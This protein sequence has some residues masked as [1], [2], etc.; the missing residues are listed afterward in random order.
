KKKE[1]SLDYNN[2]FLGE[3]EC[4]SL[5]LDKE[6]WRDE[7]KR[8]DHLKQDQTMLVIKRF[9]ERKNVFRERKKTRKIRI[10]RMLRRMPHKYQVD[11]KAAIEVVGY[12][13]GYNGACWLLWRL[14][15]KLLLRRLSHRLK[16]VVKAA[17]L[18][19]GFRMLRR[20]PHKYQ[21]DVKAAIEVAAMK[22]ITELAGFYEGC[23]IAKKVKMELAGSCGELAGF[24]RGCHTAKNVE[25]ERLALVEAVIY[26]VG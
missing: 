12:C 6:E 17:G 24:Y 22:A 21:V 26:V 23:H 20:L 16:A 5:A 14:P 9:S 11:A 8:F 4:F 13:E 15:Y 25:T 18:Y 1:K 3:Y 2:S 19:K 10:E 7:K